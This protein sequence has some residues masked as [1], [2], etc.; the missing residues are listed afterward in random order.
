[1]ISPSRIHVT[2]NWPQGI[3]ILPKSDPV[4]SI[5]HQEVRRVVLAFGLGLDSRTFFVSEREFVDFETEQ[6]RIKQCM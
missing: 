1:M 5:A 6:H 4:C 2:L 3:I